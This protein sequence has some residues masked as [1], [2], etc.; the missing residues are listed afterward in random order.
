LHNGNARIESEIRHKHRSR[1]PSVGD[2]SPGI[3]RTVAPFVGLVG[4]ASSP[5]IFYRMFY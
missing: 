4:R 2:K 5:Q 3:P 1:C